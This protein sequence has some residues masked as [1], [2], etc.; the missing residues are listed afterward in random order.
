MK[1]K[2]RIEALKIFLK[3][4]SLDGLDREEIIEATKT[5]LYCCP[6]DNTMRLFKNAESKIKEIRGTK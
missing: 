3:S 1:N 6:S 2:D 5:I 4:K